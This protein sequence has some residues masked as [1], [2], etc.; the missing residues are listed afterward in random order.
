MRCHQFAYCFMVP[1][2]IFRQIRSVTVNSLCFFAF[3]HYL[4]F[5]FNI[6]Y[7]FNSVLL[8]I[9]FFWHKWQI[10][11]SSMFFSFK[12]L[13]SITRVMYLLFSFLTSCIMSHI[14][15]FFLLRSCSFFSLIFIRFNWQHVMKSLLN[16]IIL[17]RYV[18]M[19]HCWHIKYIVIEILTA[20]G[21][22]NRSFP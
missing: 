10:S 3:R 21:R 1:L 18:F 6:F 17:V 20:K 8:V 19:Y 13:P 16:N 7:P 4:I 5:L 2:M 22:I 12:Y 15:I 11:N 9:S 14:Y